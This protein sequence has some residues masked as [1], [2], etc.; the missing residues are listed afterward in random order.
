MGSAR[1]AAVDVCKRMKGAA[2]QENH[3]A[4]TLT[5]VISDVLRNGAQI[6]GQ[7]TVCR[8]RI[9]KRR[10]IRHLSCV[11]AAN[12]VYRYACI[13]GRQYADVDRL[14]IDFT[15]FERRDRRI[16]YHPQRHL[17]RN[18]WIHA[19]SKMAVDT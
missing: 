19:P 5:Y 16:V 14:P 1:V 17:T 15:L 11:A 4:R 3:L 6:A 13:D 7:A 9:A 18:D 12:R 8:C 2:H 10:K